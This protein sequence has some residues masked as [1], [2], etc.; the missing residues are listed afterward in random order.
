MKQAKVSKVDFRVGEL[1][2]RVAVIVTNL[3]LEADS[4]AVVPFYIKP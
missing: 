3:E 1:F 2:P 4:R